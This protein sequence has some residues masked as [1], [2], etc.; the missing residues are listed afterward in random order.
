MRPSCPSDHPMTDVL[1]DNNF[2]SKDQA[3]NLIAYFTDSFQ[4]IEIF[5]SKIKKA[6]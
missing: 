3:A 5:E 2:N 6:C 1:E 4:T